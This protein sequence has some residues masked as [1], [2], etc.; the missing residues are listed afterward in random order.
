MWIVPD[1]RTTVHSSRSLPGRQRH[2]TLCSCGASLLLAAA[3]I[4]VKGLLVAPKTLHLP[5][6][7]QG[8][9]WTSSGSTGG[10][11]EG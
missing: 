3:K 2:W 10:W 1:P 7:S 6:V 8:Q 5:Q 4:L 11:K 9:S